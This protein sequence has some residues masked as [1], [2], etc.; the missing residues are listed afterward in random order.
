MLFAIF[1][2]ADHNTFRTEQKASNE[3]FQTWK[4]FSI[5][6]KCERQYR[7]TFYRV[8]PDATEFMRRVGDTDTHYLLHYY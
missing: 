2:C 5:F 8:W 3:I 4:V 6:Q 7:I 1:V